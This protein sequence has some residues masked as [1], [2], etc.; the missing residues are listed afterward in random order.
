MILDTIFNGV[1]DEVSGAGAGVKAVFA[2]SLTIYFIVLGHQVFSNATGNI[3]PTENSGKFRKFQRDYGYKHD[4]ND[5]KKWHK[6]NNRRSYRGRRR[7]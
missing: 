5:F 6:Q 7:W 2:L 3:M 4:Y 1:L